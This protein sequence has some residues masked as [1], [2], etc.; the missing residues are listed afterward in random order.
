MEQLFLGRILSK[1]RTMETSP[2]NST[3]CF[4][5]SPT[6]RGKKENREKSPVSA[7]RLL[8][9]TNKKETG[10]H[11]KIEATSEKKGQQIN[12]VGSQFTRPMRTGTTHSRRFKR[13]NF[14]FF[15]HHQIFFPKR[16][17]RSLRLL[18]EQTG[19]QWCWRRRRIRRI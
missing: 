19:R 15:K 18:F 11:V 5:D 6:L 14:G 12:E 7:S 3:H 16:G 1:K 2:F 10:V 9:E 13:S 4:Q 17:R 8:A